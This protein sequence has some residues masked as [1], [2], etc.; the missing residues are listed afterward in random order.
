[1]E[2]LTHYLDAVVGIAKER[3]NPD[4]LSILKNNFNIIL[5]LTL[6]NPYSQK[7]VISL[8]LMP[9]RDI[10]I[11]FSTKSEIEMKELF[12]EYWKKNTE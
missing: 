3:L 5:Q 11:F 10:I 2:F 7:I 1:V 6:V 8:A 9:L 12:L 4:E